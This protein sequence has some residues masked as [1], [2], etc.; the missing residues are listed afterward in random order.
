M[1]DL[2]TALR[3]AAR[4][5][6]P[7]PTSVWVEGPV[8]S[9][10]DRSDDPL[11]CCVLSNPAVL[12][13]LTDRLSERM[14][15]I[16]RD[17]D[18]TIEVRGMTRS[19][20]LARSKAETASLRDAILLAGIPPESFRPDAVRSRA[21]VIRSH[22]DH[23][24]RARRLAL[25]IA[26]KLKRDP[27]LLHAAREQLRTRR[28]AASPSEQRELL[29]WTRILATMPPSRLQRFLAEPSE[30]ATRLRQTLPLLDILSPAERTAVLAS[31]SDT[32]VRDIIARRRGR[33][34]VK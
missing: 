3:E 4:T 29:E 6:K 26:L 27:D 33:S 16:E 21:R 17:A 19:D 5:L 18:V 24:V 8:L 20:L 13:E 11:I 2:L 12:A 23:D 7:A 10:V 28:R 31:T 30:R 32:E 34:R 1:E 14:I 9:R 15:P 25:A 22:E